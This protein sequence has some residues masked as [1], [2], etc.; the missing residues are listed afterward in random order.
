MT[1]HELQIVLNAPLRSA[2]V[3]DW[4]KQPIYRLLMRLPWRMDHNGAVR[5]SLEPFDQPP[6]VIHRTFLRMWRFYRS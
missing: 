4:R 1:V 5:I 6:D 2:L 3:V